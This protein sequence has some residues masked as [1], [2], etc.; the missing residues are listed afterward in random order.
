[1]S[2]VFKQGLGVLNTHTAHGNKHNG[3]HNIKCCCS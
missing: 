3:W 2:E 1:M